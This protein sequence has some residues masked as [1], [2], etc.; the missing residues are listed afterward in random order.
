MIDTQ[1]EQEEST[2]EGGLEY[3]VKHSRDPA[4]HQKCQGK[5]GVCN[6]NMKFNIYSVMYRI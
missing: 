5:Q 3:G 4:V 2:Q 6:V 1:P